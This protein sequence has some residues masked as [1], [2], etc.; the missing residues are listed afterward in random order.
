MHA[1]AHVHARSELFRKGLT[2]DAMRAVKR[3]NLRGY[4]STPGIAQHVIR[5]LAAAGLKV[6]G[7]VGVGVG[8]GGGSR[9]G[10]GVHTTRRACVVRGGACGPGG[11]GGYD[12]AVLH[13][14]AQLPRALPAPPHPTPP[15]PLRVP[16]LLPPPPCCA[17]CCAQDEAWQE[18]STLVAL[19][20]KP[21][22]EHYRHLVRLE[23]AKGE[24]LR[25]CIT[26]S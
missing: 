3:G 15:S 19:G 17:A 6:G 14:A 2:A 12:N 24:A 18:M 7:S 26:S 21:G 13:C 16:L 8:A 20:L 1:R 25:G 10:S 11:A 9:R 5:E 23:A 4:V 22:P